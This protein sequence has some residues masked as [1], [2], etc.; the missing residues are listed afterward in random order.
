LQIVFSLRVKISDFGLSFQF[1]AKANFHKLI[2]Q[3]CGT[4][5]Y[6]APEQHA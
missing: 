3:R 4:I 2:H 1:E 6:M 5:L